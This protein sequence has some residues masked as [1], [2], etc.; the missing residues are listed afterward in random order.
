MED[1]F[2]KTKGGEPTHE[3]ESDTNYVA[4]TFRGGATYKPKFEK[5]QL[6]ALKRSKVLFQHRNDFLP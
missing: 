4:P 6:T 5:F 2:T 1:K 3:Q